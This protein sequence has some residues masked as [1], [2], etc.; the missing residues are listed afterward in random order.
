MLALVNEARMDAR[1]RP[2][3]W[4][5]GLGRAARAHSTDMVTN[6]CFQHDSC[7][8]ESW[9]TRIGRYYPWYALGENIAMGLNDPRSLHEGWMASGPHRSNILGSFSEF[10][11]GLVL[12]TTGFGQFAY[13]TADYGDRNAVP[14]SAIPTLPAGGASPRL[15]V[16]AT[17]ELFVNYYS[18]TGGAPQS[19]RALVGD[20][21]VA[22]SRTAGTAS[23]GTYGV[24]LTFPEDGCIP[25]VFEAIRADGVRVRWPA[26]GAIVVGI[27][28]SGLSCPDTTT[29]V[30]TQDCGGSNQ[31]TPTPTPT[32]TPTPVPT[33]TPVR[34]PT[35]TPSPTPYDGDVLADVRVTLRPGK[36]GAGAGSVSLEGILHPPA[37]FAPASAPLAVEIAPW[38][39]TPWT[40]L[41]PATCDDRPCLIGNVRGTSFRGRLGDVSVSL[42][43]RSDGRWKLRLTAKRQVL[44]ELQSGTVDV[45]VTVGGAT[46]TGT[47]DGRVRANGTMT[48]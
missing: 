31:P 20:Q 12:G 48:R 33:A 47:M 2:L 28:M 21:C 45:A 25:V 34:T 8:G 30:P 43:Q 23:S 26:S 6:G 39:A 3:V 32:K 1:L 44:G 24:D 16:D 18:A 13:A 41:L 22:L 40:A 38:D 15:G 19:V 10:G 14:L 7:N 35:P 27:G 37:D 42:A 5:D 29:A 17:R 4:N 36:P 9:A 11:G 46:Y